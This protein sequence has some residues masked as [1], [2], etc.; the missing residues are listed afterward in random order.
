MHLH[1]AIAV[2]AGQALWAV[3]VG[4]LMLRSGLDVPSNGKGGSPKD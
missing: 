1:A 4:W 2:Y 3:L